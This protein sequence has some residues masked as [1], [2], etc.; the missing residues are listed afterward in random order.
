MRISQRKKGS[1]WT[2]QVT[3]ECNKPNDQ[4]KLKP[5]RSIRNTK[6]VAILHILA[7]ETFGA[8]I[9]QTHD[10]SVQSLSG[11]RG[12]IQIQDMNRTEK[13]SEKLKGCNNYP[14]SSTHHKQT[15]VTAGHEKPKKQHP[16]VAKVVT[17][18]DDVS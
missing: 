2:I 17:K 7:T 6:T 12:I 9:N 10:D 13:R 5:G 4:V 18:H 1:A 8:E 11:T 3:S 16:N 14:K 15:G